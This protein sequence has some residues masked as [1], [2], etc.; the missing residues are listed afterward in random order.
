MNTMLRGKYFYLLP[1]GPL[2]LLIMLM[3]AFGFWEMRTIDLSWF[4]SRTAAPVQAVGMGGR[5]GGGSGG[6]PI[7]GGGNTDNGGIGLPAG[8]GGSQAGGG[9]DS[10][11]SGGASSGS[12]A[13]SGGG[14]GGGA[15]LPKGVQLSIAMTASAVEV[16][17]G[18]EFE[19]RVVIVNKSTTM[20]GND[21]TLQNTLP[22]GFSFVG[23]GGNSRVWNLPP[24]GP[25]NSQTVAYNVSVDVGT[26]GGSYINIAVADTSNSD[27]VQAD[28]SVIVIAP[29]V[30]GVE[31]DT[32]SLTPAAKPTTTV[33]LRLDDGTLPD[34]AGTFTSLGLLM[35]AAVGYFLTLVLVSAL[36]FRPQTLKRILL[37]TI[38]VGSS[39]WFLKVAVSNVSHQAQARAD[40]AILE[41]ITVKPRD[42]MDHVSIRPLSSS[43]MVE[44]KM[45]S[46]AAKTA[47]APQETNRLI[48]PDIG[49]DS[50]ILEGDATT[51]D[52]GLWHVGGTANPPD[53]GN[54]VI[55]GHRYKWLPPSTKT[56]WNL[57]RLEIG[58]RI[59][60]DW[61]GRRYAYKVVASDIVAPDRLDILD[62]HG[63]SELTLFT[64][65]PK[66][67]NTHRLVIRAEQVDAP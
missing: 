16:E 15:P 32:E 11:S 50:E 38:I 67:D 62:D 19:Y 36:L 7:Q 42:P 9:S 23:A 40:Q 58:D 39:I 17:A 48:I 3:G 4:F 27:P 57:D 21:L 61:Q 5:G 35:F 12:G 41:H 55:S 56:F 64:C 30:L 14:V 65:T 13:S 2:V 10:G 52:N 6:G 46:V 47:I 49:V 63:L 25:G 26:V 1:R 24:L 60:I 18:G 44:L 37:V 51:L 31:F 8:S 45:A 20:V 53:G 66:F 22:A 33:P 34:S 29:E 54:V 28:V 43:E 59:F